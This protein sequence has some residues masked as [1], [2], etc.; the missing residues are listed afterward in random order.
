[1]ASVSNSGSAKLPKKHIKQLDYDE[2]SLPLTND[3]FAAAFDKMARAVEPRLNNDSPPFEFKPVQVSPEKSPN[4]G[5]NVWWRHHRYCGKYSKDDDVGYDVRLQYSLQG[6]AGFA[7]VGFTPSHVSGV[8]LSVNITDNPRSAKFGCVLWIIFGV[9][10]GIGV[11]QDTKSFVAAFLIGGI[12]G[13]VIGMILGK[14]L[15]LILPGSKE[16]IRSEESRRLAHTAF[17]SIS[18]I[19]TDFEKNIQQHKKGIGHD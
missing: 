4:V 1:M 12:G 13:A 14:L 6:T 19:W 3:A 8:S 16:R 10:V 7:G 15:S 9:L 11:Y 5:S 2:G 17:N 18:E